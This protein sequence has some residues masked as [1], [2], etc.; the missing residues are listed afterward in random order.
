M[1]FT[2]VFLFGT[3]HSAET[4]AFLQCI[5]AKIDSQ[6]KLL[7]IDGSVTVQT[8]RQPLDSW[9]QYKEEEGSSTTDFITHCFNAEFNFLQLSNICYIRKIMIT[10]DPNDLL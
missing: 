2:F 9:L 6:Q 10:S 1:F 5:P 4:D 8:H 3:N 7:E